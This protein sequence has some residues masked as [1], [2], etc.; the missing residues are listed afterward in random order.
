MSY[1]AMDIQHAEISVPK[2]LSYYGVVSHHCIIISNIYQGYLMWWKWAG[3]QLRCDSARV[4]TT[5][6]LLK[7]GCERFIFIFLALMNSEIHHIWHQMH[8]LSHIPHMPI[9]AMQ[10]NVY[11]TAS[12]PMYMKI[13]AQTIKLVIQFVCF[14]EWVFMYMY[15]RINIVAYWLLLY[16]AFIQNCRVEIWDMYFSQTQKLG[17]KTWLDCFE[18]GHSWDFTPSRLDLRL[19][20]KNIQIPCFDLVNSWTN[21]KWIMHRP[22]T[23]RLCIAKQTPWI[24]D[25][26]A[27][28]NHLV[29]AMYKARFTF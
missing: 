27:Y 17:F 26:F 16:S 13:L 9:Q 10:C 5:R 24:I 20:N 14:Y 28:W 23:G 11:P 19:E 4:Y 1:F 8:F 2:Y 12:Y 7:L 21:E 6:S 25:Y 15:L 3:N 22:K 18:T 29:S